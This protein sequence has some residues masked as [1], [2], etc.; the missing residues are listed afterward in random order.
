MGRKVSK[1]G[2]SAPVVPA[3]VAIL[4]LGPSLSEYL[5]LTKRLGG[6]RA[7][8]DE[9]WAINALGG[10]FQA[11]RVFHMDDVR[12]QQIRVDAN[13]KSNIAPMLAWLKQHH[14]PVYTSFAHKDYPALVEFPLESVINDLG[15]A[16]FNS[17][18]AYAV[19]Y[20]MHIGVKKLFLFGMD[21]T[22]PNAHHAEKGR[23]CVEF[24]IGRAM[25]LGIDVRI[26]RNSSLMDGCLPQSAR[27]Y[28]YDCA[29][30]EIKDRGK[31]KHVTFKPKA[32][33]TAEQVEA[34]Y[35]HNTHPNPL[36]KKA[37]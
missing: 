14:G 33:P 23:A 25:L 24:W 34:A 22:Y 30:V 20:A 4:G 5:E 26:P 29:D 31:R 7:L 13:P 3:S 36:V 28:G 19:A 16:Y 17:T 8:C 6:A 21:F 2:A 1:A 9:T 27:L 32:P 12:V 35:D 15:F 10:V 11:D 18:A 37:A